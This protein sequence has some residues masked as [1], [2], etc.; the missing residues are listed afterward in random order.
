MSFLTS[1]TSALHPPAVHFF[2]T[3]AGRTPLRLP[4][5]SRALKEK[6]ASRPVQ[7]SQDRQRVATNHLKVSKIPKSEP[8]QLLH[9]FRSLPLC[10]RGQKQIPRVSLDSQS[11]EAD[12]MASDSDGLS[13]VGQKT[14]LN[15]CQSLPMDA[16]KV[17]ILFAWGLDV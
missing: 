3:L 14:P 7:A 8:S 1:I 13:S 6:A 16:R 5:G 17:C 10:I 4:L 15:L 9:L 11:T 2:R 12:A